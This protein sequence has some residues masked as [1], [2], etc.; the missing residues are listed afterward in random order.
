MIHIQLNLLCENYFNYKNAHSRDDMQ[1]NYK[2][3]V[4]RI[5][6][7]MVFYFFGGEGKT[8]PLLLVYCFIGKIVATVSR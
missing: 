8:V 3:V 6:H 1:C 4:I 5:V 7:W 2:I